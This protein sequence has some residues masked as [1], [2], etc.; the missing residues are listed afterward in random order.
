MIPLFSGLI[1][2]L[3]RSVKVNENKCNCSVFEDETRLKCSHFIIYY[4][5]KF[6]VD[7]GVSD[8]FNYITAMF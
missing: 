4:S 7:Q 8:I 6:L 1:A 2:V 5:L 3:M